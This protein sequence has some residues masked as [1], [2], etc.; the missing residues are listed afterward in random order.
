MI[1]IILFNIIEILNNMIFFDIAKIEKLIFRVIW[2]IVSG[3][4]KI[5]LFSRQLNYQILDFDDGHF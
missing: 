1:F 2:L 5:N 3:Q 4:L